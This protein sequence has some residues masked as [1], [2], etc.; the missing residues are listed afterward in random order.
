MEIKQYFANKFKLE[1][2]EIRIFYDKSNE[3]IEGM[4][5]DHRFWKE[6]QR[7]FIFQIEFSHQK[8]LIIKYGIDSQK[9]F[10]ISENLQ[11]KALKKLTQ[12]TTNIVSSRQIW[13]LIDPE[14]RKGEILTDDRFIRDLN[15]SQNIFVE[16]C[17]IN[18]IQ[19]D[20][21]GIKEDL[22]NYPSC[23]EK[24]ILQLYFSLDSV[25]NITSANIPDYN[26][27]IL[28]IKRNYE[29]NSPYFFLP[30]ES[31]DLMIKDL[32]NKDKI[33]LQKNIIHLFQTINPINIESLT[34][35]LH[36]S[37]KACQQIKDKQ[38]FLFLGYTGVGKSTIICFLSFY[39]MVSENNRIEVAPGYS[40]PCK[41]SGTTNSETRGIQPI[42]VALNGKISYYYDNKRVIFCDTAGFC[43]TNGD[44]LDLLNGLSII[45]VAQHA[46]EV[47]PI[48]VI[49]KSSLGGRY[50]NIISL[51]Y[52]LIGMIPKI[53][54]FVKSI[55]YL[56][57]NF[58]E[59]EKKNVESGL[60]DLYQKISEENI[61]NV[62]VVKQI[63]Y[64][65]KENVIIVDPLN[66]KPE[67]ILKNGLKE[68]SLYI[69]NPD[70]CFASNFSYKSKSFQTTRDQTT[71]IQKALE[72]YLKLKDYKMVDFK[73]QQLKLFSDL[74]PNLK[75][76]YEKSV[77]ESAIDLNNRFQNEI[78]LFKINMRE[79]K[80]LD[81]EECEQFYNEVKTLDQLEIL[82]TN[83]LENNLM[84]YKFVL[85]QIEEQINM[86][87]NAIQLKFFSDEKT[88]F[89]LKKLDLV[90]NFFPNFK[91]SLF[92]AVI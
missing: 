56:F 58:E 67:E 18:K 74:L 22:N 19:K 42:E 85:Q 5:L 33:S 80:T 25:E 40:A 84:F 39:P 6:K 37:D 48:I 36:L 69:P 82:R 46:S 52:N 64:H 10:E 72:Y 29:N 62:E 2:E 34:R 16:I 61:E 86:V 9:N 17:E 75:N 32:Y 31:F 71:L 59:S 53:G 73:L 81:K 12:E 35:N 91:D 66:Q 54:S 90:A 38:I 92:K 89:L 77:K 27:E 65:M 41:I 24:D 28:E 60:N 45:K 26:K 43:D 1:K 47:K 76:E 63:L 14:E 68:D 11:I 3:L 23:L 70:E 44:Q 87:N 88:L 20:F 15:L 30:K 8:T 49:S 55:C 83:H 51:I 13:K 78:N 79:D 21:E 57:T 4:L 50:E 7:E